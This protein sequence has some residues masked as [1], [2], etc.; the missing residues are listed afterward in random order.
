MNFKKLFTVVGAGLLLATSLVVTAQEAAQIVRPT[1]AA[2]SPTKSEP[3]QKPVATSTATQAGTSAPAK[4]GSRVV[5][6]PQIE[7]TAKVAASSSAVDQDTPPLKQE[8]QL[9]Q[10]THSTDAARIHETVNIVDT[11][12]AVKY[13]PS[14][15]TRK[16]VIGDTQAVLAT[17]TWGLNSSARSLVY[18]DD[19]LLSALIGNNNTN[20]S[21]RWGLVSPEEISRI[22]MLYGPYA[23]MYPGNSEGGVLQITTKMPEK[24]VA[25]AAQTE[26]F[27]TYSQYGTSGTYRTDQTNFVLGNKNGDVSWLIMENFLNTYSQPLYFIT[28]STPPAGTNGAYI[29]KNKVGA[30]ADVV[31]AGGL[32]HSQQNTATGKMSWDINPE[33]NLTYQIGFFYNDTSAQSQS[34]LHNAIT[35]APTFGP[36][37]GASYMKTFGSDNYTLDEE[38]IANSFSL[39]SKTNGDFDWDVSASNYYY[40]EDI[41]RNPY[42]AL[43]NSTNFT[44]YGTINNMTGT[45][46]SNGD[47]KGIVRPDGPDG[48]HE[49][50]FGVHGDREE[51]RNPTYA[52]PTWNDSPNTS[53][54]Q[55]SNGRGT[56]WTEALWAQDAWK[57]APD[58]KLTLGGR[59]ENWQ[60][61]NGYNIATTQSGSNSGAITKTVATNQPNLDAF[62]F[63]PKLSLTW[64]AQ[65]D[66]E[67]TGSFGEAYRFPTVSELYQASAS[68]SN[69]YVPNPN[70]KPEDDISLELAVKKT[71][72]DGAVRL[73]AFND[74]VH[75]A[76]ISQT[77]FITGG[78]SFTTVSNVTEIRN[79]GIE[80]DAQKD[81][82]FVHGLS[83]FGNMTWVNSNIVSDPSFVSTT[84]TTATG[85]KVPYVPNWR[86]SFG[87]TYHPIDNLALTAAM[88]YSG[89]QY[90]TLDNTDNTPDVFGAF[91][92]FFVVDLHAEYKITN[93]F[94][95]DAG[96][97]NVNN[98]KYFLYHPF[99]QRTY[100]ASLRFKF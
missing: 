36:T 3:A 18:A 73:S 35:G 85:K 80:L 62:R 46:W 15:F 52:T 14:L 27:Q 31:G 38:H 10:T 99:P 77:T 47:F 83:F 55:Y 11:E 93:R 4:A 97:D 9:P 28:N 78:S 95:A 60:A 24:F 23:A 74:Y 88:R 44:S 29:A 17:R 48:Q 86:A 20:S 13:F 2:P 57:F 96:I 76:L 49:I 94:F 8:Y 68:G 81:N 41:Q 25:D 53:S 56:T 16:R 67:V 39:K 84:G 19:I 22:D 6:L 58:Y 91:D 5:T 50:S 26:A 63:S 33:L 54:T 34:Y 92:K 43:P 30:P 70:L 89:K 51:L 1:S 45:N 12:D 75:D 66:L 37:L 21:P 98:D 87:T 79:T 59:F 32:Q 7:V 61:M 90:S 42:A 69:I 82:V 71:F 100:T 65:E 72:T 64:N 40:L